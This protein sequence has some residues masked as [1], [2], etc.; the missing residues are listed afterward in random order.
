MANG[1][2]FSPENLHREGCTF[3]QLLAQQ[4]ELSSKHLSEKLDQLV[5]QN[6]QLVKS[7]NALSVDIARQQVTSKGV[8]VIIATVISVIMSVAGW[9]VG[10]LPRG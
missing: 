2:E 8:T 5:E 7:V 1:H 6:E 3:G 4:V 9:F 10:H